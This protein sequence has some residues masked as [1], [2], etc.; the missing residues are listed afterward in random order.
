MK[1]LKVILSLLIVS[2]LISGCTPKVIVKKVFIEPTKYNF[3]KVDFSGA[4][5][6]LTDEQINICKEPLEILK[7]SYKSTKEIYDEQFDDYKKAYENDA[8][9]IKELNKE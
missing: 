3:E 2:T 8:R 5:I 1:S 4:Y 7:N 9:R 6:E